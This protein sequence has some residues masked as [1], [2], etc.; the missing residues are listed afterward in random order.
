M[1][2]SKDIINKLGILKNQLLIFAVL[3]CVVLNG[4]AYG[5][6]KSTVRIQQSGGL[7]MHF[8]SILIAFAAFAFYIYAYLKLPSSTQEMV[9]VKEAETITKEH[10][11]NRKKS[12][13]AAGKDAPV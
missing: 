4:S 3:I 1:L 11:R 6:D 7:V 8:A 10:E 5:L 13:K 2:N 9:F 12:T